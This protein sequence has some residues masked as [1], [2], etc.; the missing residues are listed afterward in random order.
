MSYYPIVGDESA[1]NATAVTI[2]VNDQDTF[3]YQASVAITEGTALA[4]TIT[5][6]IK[7]FGMNTYQ[8]LTD[9][10]DCTALVPARIEGKFSAIKFT[11]SSLTAG[12]KF[13][14]YLDKMEVA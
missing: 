4:G 3:K 10:F 5:V 13:T 9:T 2:S 8:D 7:P 6:S 12:C 14:P 11:P 1:D